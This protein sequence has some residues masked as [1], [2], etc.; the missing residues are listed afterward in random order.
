MHI[1]IFVS[2]I[3]VV[4][5][6]GGISFADGSLISVE[7]DSENYSEG[8]I[9]LISGN[10]STIIGNTQVSL[11]LFQDGTLIDV[12]QI[13]VGQDGNYV[14]RINAQGP[15]WKNP[16]VYTIK[17]VY[18]EA[19]VAEKSFNYLPL[20]DVVETTSNFE[21]NAGDSGTFDIKYT[22]RGGTIEEIKIQ[23]EIFGLILKIDSTTNGNLVIDLPRQF[24]DAEKQNGKDEVFIVMV[25]N[26][27]SPYSEIT[28]FSEFRTI[29]IDFEKGD[30]D[31]QIIGTYVIPE[32]GT[33]V[34]II[35]TIGIM[36]SVLLTKNRFQFK[37]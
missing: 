29:I 16:G 4:M 27:Q 34:M 35:L 18:G 28:T 25:D 2:L 17:V 14:T 13:E 37:I 12:D 24:I 22:I 30:S 11:Q 31:I 8:D 33:I 19:N 36:S 5:I 9:I 10:I 23:P 1:P 6:S 21:V 15:L 7:T 26:V 32:F 20:S 3:M